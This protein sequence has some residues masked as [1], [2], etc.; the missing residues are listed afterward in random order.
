MERRWNKY[1][2]TLYTVTLLEKYNFQRLKEQQSRIH[3][4]MSDT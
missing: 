3:V 1:T 2:V 4:N